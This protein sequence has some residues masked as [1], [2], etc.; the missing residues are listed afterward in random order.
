MERASK[1][2]KRRADAGFQPRGSI[3][4]SEHLFVVAKSKTPLHLQ[5]TG[6]TTT[7]SKAIQHRCWEARAFE[8]E[9][10]K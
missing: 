3:L 4:E 10:E 5:P 1:D 8:R 9:R 7:A 2:P 6:L